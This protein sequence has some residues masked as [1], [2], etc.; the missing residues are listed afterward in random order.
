MVFRVKNAQL[1]KKS[2]STRV[3]FLLFILSVSFLFVQIC[4]VSA[5]DEPASITGTIS[6]EGLDTDNDGSF[7]ELI[8]GVEINVTTPGTYTV[9]VASLYDE[10]NNP[11]Y[12]SNKTT[13]FLDA[14]LQFVNVSLD[15]A[16]IYISGINPSAI[17]IIDLYDESDETIDEEFSIPLSE[18]YPY[19]GF[20]HGPSEFN[21]NEIQRKIILD[22]TGTIHITNVYSITNVGFPVGTI[23][24]SY[25][26]GAYD[27]QVRD[28]M[29]SLKTTTNNETLTVT[30]RNS[31]A[32]NETETIYINYY[33]PWENHI[34]QQDGIDY[35]LSFS[36]SDRLN[37]TIETFTVSIT[38]PKGANFKSSVNLNPN[39][40]EESELQ[41]TL[42]F[43]FS[44]VTPSDNF[45]FEINYEYTVFWGSFYPTLWVGILA[46]VASAVFFFWGTPKTIAAPT[47]QVPSKDLKSFVDN[48]E[49]KT[50]VESELENLEDRLKKGKIPRRRYKVRKK[51]LEGRLST[52]NR[53]LSTLRG[54]IRSSGSKYSRLMNDL[55]IA[56]AN[57]ECAE[58]DMQRVKSRYA[59]GKISKSA[60]GKLLEEYESRIEDAETTIDGVLLRLRE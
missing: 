23:G 12:V 5:Q 44:D 46:I 16:T 15:G 8:I 3:I 22:Q 40:I 17:A 11:I 48:Y 10:S 50:T 42:T 33:L 59:R 18:M 41:E 52:I 37:S 43:S 31:L 51:M 7:D 19:T 24:F 32:V 14:G 13:T 39:N 54:T 1:H 55:E 2:V 60:Y 30:L 49:D 56:E 29:G 26:E 25:P 45:D 9:E 57:L 20:Q 36:F 4:A 34:T 28:V 27:F 35:T 47:I 6:D 58:Q 21:Y 38:L 53:N